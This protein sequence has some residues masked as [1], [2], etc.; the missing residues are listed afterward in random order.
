MHVTAPTDCS[1]P[2]P[3]P[4]GAVLGVDAKAGETIEVPDAVGRSLVDQGWAQAKAP[5]KAKTAAKP[6]ED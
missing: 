3:S 1:V 2:I 4:D 6:Q 5:S